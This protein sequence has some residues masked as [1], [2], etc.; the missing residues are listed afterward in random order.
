MKCNRWERRR[1]RRQEWCVR[2]AGGGCSVLRSV[3]PV[4]GVNVL[5]QLSWMKR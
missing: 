2:A 5:F 3:S 4:W 1:A